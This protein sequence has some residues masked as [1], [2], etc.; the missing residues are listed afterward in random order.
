MAINHPK[1]I[2]MRLDKRKGIESGST[3]AVDGERSQEERKKIES[4]KA[5]DRER[6]DA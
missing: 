2:K 3:K 1:Y 4:T 6:C 5:V